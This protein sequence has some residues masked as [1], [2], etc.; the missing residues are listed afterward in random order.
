V[1]T[2][3]Q[4]WTAHP[5]ENQWLRDLILDIGFL[6]EL[7]AKSGLREAGCAKLDEFH[8]R[9]SELARKAD[10][11]GLSLE[12]ATADVVASEKMYCGP[13][14]SQRDG[15]NPANHKN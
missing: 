13:K 2:D 9:A 6:G 5:A 15:A 10:P 3:Q 4:S 11:K 14:L 12:E 1:K 8:R 7:E